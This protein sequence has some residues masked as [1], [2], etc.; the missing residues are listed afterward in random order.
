M[1]VCVYVLYNSTTIYICSRIDK[2]INQPFF[3]HCKNYAIV[4][5]RLA[6]Q[7]VISA[8]CHKVIYFGR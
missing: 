3:L 4:Q 8:L 6:R 2:S 7:T 1:C 5:K